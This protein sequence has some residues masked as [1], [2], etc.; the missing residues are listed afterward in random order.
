MHELIGV[1][2]AH[3][4]RALHYTLLI[5]GKEAGIRRFC[6]WAIGMAVL[7]LRKIA[8]NPQFTSGAQVKIKRSAVAMTRLLTAVALRNDWLLRRLF[9]FAARGLPLANLGEV[10]RPQRAA[11]TTPADEPELMRSYGS[12]AI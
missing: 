6:L 11:R 1:A 5:P 7:T 4:R 8:H 2:H 3:L 10:R 12:T 9:R